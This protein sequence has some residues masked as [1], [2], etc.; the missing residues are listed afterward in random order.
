MRLTVSAVLTFQLL[1]QIV[2]GVDI[3][4]TRHGDGDIFIIE[5]KQ[6]INIK[7]SK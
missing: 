5:G 2:L 1:V 3:L 7:I 6:N 4:V